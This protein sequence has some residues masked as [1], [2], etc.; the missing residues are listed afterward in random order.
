MLDSGSRLIST[1]PKSAKSA[2]LKV[3]NLERR[4]KQM[5]LRLSTERLT[6]LEREP[7]RFP[8]QSWR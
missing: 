5:C 3:R 6:G 2:T 8:S 4:N 1:L 7:S